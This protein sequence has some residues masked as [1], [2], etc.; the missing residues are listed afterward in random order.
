MRILS[1]KS[2]VCLMY[3]TEK[4]FEVKSLVWV[5]LGH[6]FGLIFMYSTAM[7]H[8]I[9]F[10]FLFAYCKLS[11]SECPYPESESCL[12]LYIMQPHVRPL[13]G[14]VMWSL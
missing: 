1:V 12:S 5:Q 14:T 9:N 7:K 6:I 2:P 10:W 3:L 11:L 13:F 4:V 8:V